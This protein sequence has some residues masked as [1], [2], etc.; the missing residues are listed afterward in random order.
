M[1]RHDAKGAKRGLLTK[2]QQAELQKRLD[3]LE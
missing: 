2:E 3:R 1:N